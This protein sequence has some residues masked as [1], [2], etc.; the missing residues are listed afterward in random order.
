[1]ASKED[2]V[3]WITVKYYADGSMSTSGNIG[4]AHFAIALLDHAKDA[5]RGNARPRT[6]IVTP[7]RDVVVEQSPG[8]PTRPLGDM[9]PADRGDGA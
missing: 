8:Y 3:A 5:V 9:A 1:M 7:S 4:D 6:E 2:C